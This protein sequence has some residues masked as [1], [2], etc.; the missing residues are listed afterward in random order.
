MAKAPYASLTDLGQRVLPRRVSGAKQLALKVRPSECGGLIA[1]LDD[2][3]AL[4]GLEVGGD[5]EGA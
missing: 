3:D 2:V 1:A 4:D 5:A